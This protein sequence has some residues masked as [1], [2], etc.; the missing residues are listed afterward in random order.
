M[1]SKA[2]PQSE[3]QQPAWKGQR[4]SMHFLARLMNSP[5]FLILIS[6]FG[7]YTLTLNGMWGTDHA[8]S[9]LQL[10]WAI[11]NN[12]SFALGSA[13]N[14]VPHSV[15]DFLYKGYY[16]SALAPGTAIM[17]L[18]FAAIGF[19]LNGSSF[20]IFGY[21]MLFSELYIAV[22]A[23]IGAMLVY[24]ISRMFLGEAT[25]V[26]LSFAYAFSTIVWPFA[27]FFFQSDPSATL[28]LVAA[29]L[30]LR[31]GK[32]GKRGM[33]SFVFC[34]LAIGSALT[35][36]YVNAILIPIIFIY[37]AISVRKSR[38]I[39]VQTKFDIVTKF[40]GFLLA[41]SEGVLLIGAYNYVN[42]GDF[43]ASTEQ[44]YLGSSAFFGNFTY[45]IY[46]GVVLNLFTPFRG[47]FFYC[48]IL[49]VGAFG[50]YGML[51]KDKH[52]LLFLALFLGLLLPYSAWYDPTGGLSYGPRFVVPAIPFL[53]IPAGFLLENARS[54]GLRDKRILVTYLLYAC[55][56]VMNGV[57]AITSALGPASGPW[58][59]S[60]FFNYIGIAPTLMYFLTG[61]VDSWSVRIFG[62]NWWVVA[63][64]I[65]I[66]TLLVPLIVH[67]RMLQNEPIRI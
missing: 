58:Y 10:D 23:S 30:A 45:P 42:F 17:A 9:F 27:T 50:F 14:F 3:S 35:V 43:F 1:H 16:Y 63:S 65:I 4:K 18:P 60:P 20:S 33:A 48:P 37:L 39:L 7:I 36:D 66:I 8:T 6:T 12:H 24:K 22:M 34:G 64:L 46:F 38:K 67:R 57:A 44:I 51:R 15:D 26:F 19:M 21:P 25:S 2:S 49:I 56:A 61:L 41:C 5:S 54:Y 59:L 31:I 29:F 40:L 13:G 47:L 52:T 32:Q 62:S 11:L 55:G 28:D 53:L